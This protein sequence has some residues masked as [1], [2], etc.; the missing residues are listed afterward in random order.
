M[1][2]VSPVGDWRKPT[3]EVNRVRILHLEDSA[4]DAALIL[5]VL[6]DKELPC[7]ITHALHRSEFESAVERDRFDVILCDNHLPGYSGFDALEFARKHQPDVPVIILSGTL[8]DEQAVECLKKGAT[9]YILKERLARLV[10]AIRRALDEADQ[11]IIKAAADERIREQAGLLNL[12][13]DAILVRNMNDRI[14]YWNAGAKTLFGWTEEQA[15]GQDFGTFLQADKA[16]LREA[17][18]RLLKEDDWMGEIKL[19]SKSGQEITVL[20]RW[21]LLRGPDGKPRS[22]ICTNTD[23]S[24]LKR[25]EKALSEAR[26]MQNIGVLA[27]GIVDDLNNTL[28]PALARPAP[29]MDVIRSSAQRATNL[30]QR[31]LAVTRGADANFDVPVT[32]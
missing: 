23:I 15:N 31:I 1:K 3:L 19:K 30:A 4:A 20:S 9:D 7:A 18:E 27:D 22:I 24:E 17:K 5:D 29:S 32:S 8:D 14:Q 6:E 13:S 10:P 11:R 25:L 28:S 16:A 21:N 12:T 26:R 2:E